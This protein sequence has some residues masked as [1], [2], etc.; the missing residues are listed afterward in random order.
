MLAAQSLVERW[1]RERE[2]VGEDSD[3]ARRSQALIANLVEWSLP[4]ERGTDVSSAWQWRV[5]L[6]DAQGVEAVHVSELLS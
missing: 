1:V 2:E 5:T 6:R 3:D 4:R